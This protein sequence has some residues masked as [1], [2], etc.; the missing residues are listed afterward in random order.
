MRESLAG[1]LRAA[2]ISGL[3]ASATTAA[4]VA[5]RARR[6]TGS[7]IAPINATSHVAWGDEATQVEPVDVKH[8]ALGAA[9]HA[10]A[11]VLWAALY[12]KLFGARAERGDVGAAVAG[13][14]AIAALAY[15]VDHHALPRRLT[16][17]WERRV[18]TRSVLF[19]YGVLAASLPLRA[20][21]RRRR[22]R[23]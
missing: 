14:A 18:S 19:T 17:G 23:L 12:E 9:I 16:P 4:A 8:S 21:L 22:S 6:E 13:G 20:W 15:V 11:G 2:A 10:S 7:A 5:L 1:L 3:L